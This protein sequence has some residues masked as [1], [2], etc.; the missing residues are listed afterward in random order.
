EDDR[1]S[2]AEIGMIA[3]IYGSYA[4]TSPEAYDL[5]E[6]RLAAGCESPDR[7][8][9][10]MQ[11]LANLATSLLHMGRTDKIWPLMKHHPDPTLR[12]HLIENLGAVGVS[13]KV[14]TTRLEQEE[15]ASIQAAILLSLLEFGPKRLSAVDQKQ[16]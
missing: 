15:D 3:T 14:L 13:P 10:S 11:G 2:G 1:R 5:L 8:G 4:A 7:A 6:K 12:A 16:L 9:V